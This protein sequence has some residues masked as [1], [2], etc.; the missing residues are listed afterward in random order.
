MFATEVH[1]SHQL[2]KDVGQQMVIKINL[3]IIKILHEHNFKN[4]ERNMIA[5]SYLLSDAMMH[6]ACPVLGGYRNMCEDHKYPKRRT[7]PTTASLSTTK[8]LKTI[9]NDNVYC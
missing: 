9:F 4:L 1:F 5:V 7:R 2:N 6:F 3:M 8:S